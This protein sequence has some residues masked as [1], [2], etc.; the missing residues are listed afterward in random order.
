M[1]LSNRRSL[2]LSRPISILI[3]SKLSAWFGGAFISMLGAWLP[4]YSARNWIVIAELSDQMPSVGWFVV[5]LQFA[6]KIL[7]FFAYHMA[8]AAD[9]AWK[10]PQSCFLLLSL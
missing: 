2:K 9:P 10:R 1:L 3:K 4:A 8:W 5:F 7:S 6:P